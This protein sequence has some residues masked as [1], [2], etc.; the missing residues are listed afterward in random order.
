VPTPAEG[1]DATDFPLTWPADPGT[2]EVEIRS[3]DRR[4]VGVWE[5]VLDDATSLVDACA[6]Q[7]G[8]ACFVFGYDADAREVRIREP[9]RAD[10]GAVVDV[11]SCEAGT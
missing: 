1:S 8:R 4:Y 9:Y 3:G 11:R 7:G 10:A 6:R 2:L 5:G